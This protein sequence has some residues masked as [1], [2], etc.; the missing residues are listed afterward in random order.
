MKLLEKI[1]NVNML[2]NMMLTSAAITVTIMFAKNIASI[3]KMQ[4]TSCRI[5]DVSYVSENATCPCGFFCRSK[6]PCVRIYVN[7]SHPLPRPPYNLNTPKRLTQDLHSRKNHP[8]CSLGSLDACN[9]KPYENKN[10]KQVEDIVKSLE[11]GEFDCFYDPSNST[12]ALLR[13]QPSLSEISMWLSVCWGVA[14]FFGATSVVLC[15]RLGACSFFQRTV[16]KVL[17]FENE[18]TLK[19]RKERKRKK[20]LEEI[21]NES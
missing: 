17:P 15:C 8:E 18:A 20:I 16:K 9:E 4:K 10:V 7:F 12:Y 5:Q 11:A 1:F 2:M 3:I 21:V 19:E 14:A 13:H 6:F